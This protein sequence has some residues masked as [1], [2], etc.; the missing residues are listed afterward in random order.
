MVAYT[1]ANGWQNKPFLGVGEFTLELGNF[2]VSITVLEDHIV[3]A[4]GALENTD[5]V[6]SEEQSRCLKQAETVDSPV[7]IVSP[8][9]AMGNQSKKSRKNKT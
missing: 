1:D 7:F 5:K 8:E 2:E 3:S 6:L 9:E 4:T